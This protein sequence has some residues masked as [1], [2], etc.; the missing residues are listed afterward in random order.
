MPSRGI[1]KTLRSGPV[2]TSWSSNARSSMWVRKILRTNTGWQENELKADYVE[3]LGSAHWWDWI[4][5]GIVLLQSRRPSISWV[6][7]S[8]TSILR[9]VI[10]PLYST[11]M[12]P[13]PQPGVL[14]S[15]LG[16]TAWKRCGPVGIGPEQ[17]TSVIRGLEH[18]PYYKKL[19]ELGLFR[20]EKSLQ[21][22]PY[23]SLLVSKEGLQ[24]GWKGT[25]YKSM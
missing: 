12:R 21:R 5:A 1:L 4:W 8:V 22:R 13:H 9:E 23:S 2:H 10:F 6:V 19:R 7:S 16:N 17:A 25:F 14:C 11:P 15:D 3:G 24:E 20:L 18:L